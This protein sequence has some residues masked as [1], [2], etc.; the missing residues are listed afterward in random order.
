MLRANSLTPPT[1]T[2]SGAAQSCVQGLPSFESVLTLSRECFDDDNERSDEDRESD[3]LLSV[4]RQQGD[5]YLLPGANFTCS[6]N[7]T[8]WTVGG[9]TA[10]GNPQFMPESLQIWRPSS[11]SSSTEYSIS[12]SIP[13]LECGG[14]PPTRVGADV[15]QCDLTEGVEVRPGDIL[16]ILQHRP[17]FQQFGVF[18]H[19]DAATISSPQAYRLRA[20]DSSTSL[21]QENS[22]GPL[23]PLVALQVD[24]S[25]QH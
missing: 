8:R 17:Q 25:G 24:S 10:Q 19:T 3:C 2:H 12:A 7:L 6:G 1:H 15:Y 20:G 4:Q 14:G 23:L 13:L 16:G 22:V 21:P 11:T 9:V 5:V 18:F